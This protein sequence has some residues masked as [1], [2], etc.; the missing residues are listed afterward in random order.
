MSSIRAFREGA[1]RASRAPYLLAGMWLLT[2][3][4]ALPL[5]L[6]LRG[7]LRDGLG[8][9]LAAA[10]MSSGADYEW[11]AEFSAGARGLGR[12]FTP[13]II[14]FA[15][16][17]QNISSLADGRA[18]AG[19]VAAIVAIYLVA[20]TFL[21]GGIL[22]RLAR[23][24]PTRA[25][26]F[27]SASG[28]FFFRFLRL[29]ALAGVVYYALFGWI[30]GLV[31]DSFFGWVTRDFTVERD[32]FAVRLALYTVFGALLAACGIVFDYAKVRAVVEDRR[33]MVGAL[34]AS[35]RFTARQWRP[36]I[37]L[38]LLTG[39]VFLLVVAAW[40]IVAPG[41]V[42]AGAQAWMAFLLT[43]VYVLARLWVK[44]LFY[45]SEISLFQSALAH[46]EYTAAAPPV[47]PDSPAADAIAPPGK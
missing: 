21:L 7:I 15:A 6:A 31:F 47:W 27:F 19:E 43:Q 12:T 1:R 30:H 42:A 22:D 23:N 3:L 25:H 17:L 2:L 44:L 8:G 39:V 45:A 16:V 20:W 26:G 40:A 33:S 10:S 4:L 29:A 14:G 28:V 41:A 38:Y 32:A 37:A 34:L 18:P 36:A 9:S 35:L 24:R 13:G 5:G 46:A 11:W